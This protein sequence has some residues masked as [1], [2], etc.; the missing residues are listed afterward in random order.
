MTTRDQ[1]RASGSVERGLRG[2]TV[3]VIPENGDCTRVF[4]SVDRIIHQDARPRAG[5]IRR[6]GRAELDLLLAEGVE[7]GIMKRAVRQG[8]RME[9]LRT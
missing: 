7:V 9:E 1:P 4:L 5:A 2:Y 6:V 3:T 8:R